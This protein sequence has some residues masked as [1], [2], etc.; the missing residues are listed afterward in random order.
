GC[1]PKIEFAQF[2]P[3]VYLISKAIRKPK[4]QLEFSKKFRSS[5]TVLTLLPIPV[6]RSHKKTSLES[7]R[8]IEEQGK[9]RR[10]KGEHEKGEGKRKREEEKGKKARKRRGKG[11]KR[12]NGG[13]K[14]PKGIN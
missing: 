5:Q 11:K 14:N 4:F 8:G 13:R 10:G 1:L 7:E 12:V 6:L 2:L 3:I 9:R